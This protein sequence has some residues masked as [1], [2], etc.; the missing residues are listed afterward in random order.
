MK[1]KLIIFFSCLFFLAGCHG[2]IEKQY[3][4]GLDL[5]KANRFSEALNILLPLAEKGHPASE[6]LVGFL[7][8]MNKGVPIDVQKSIYW[9]KKSAEAGNAEA[10][11]TLATLYTT[12]DGVEKNDAEALKW[13]QKAADGGI[14]SAQGVLDHYN[15]THE[16]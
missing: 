5:M 9:I 12:G 10:A 13:Y 11:E 6:H 4:Q 1:N 16:F 14:E 15:Q 7:Y 8:R 3:H 2:N